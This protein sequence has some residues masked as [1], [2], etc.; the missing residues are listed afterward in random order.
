LG[1]NAL[2]TK[3]AQPIG[4]AFLVFAKGVKSTIA[5]NKLN[6]VFK[7]AN[8]YRTSVSYKALKAEATALMLK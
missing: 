4:W 8:A 7:E 2:R 3:K 5:G 1:T 6:W